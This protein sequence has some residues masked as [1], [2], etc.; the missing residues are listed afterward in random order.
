MPDKAPLVEC[1][2]NFSE[3]RRMDVQDAIAESI[4]SVQGVRLL[5]RTSD[6]DHNRTVMTFSGAP[7]PVAEA[8]FRAIRTAAQLIDLEQHEGVHPR[9]GA[10]DVLPFVPLRGATMEG[11]VLLAR[12]LGQR[13]GQELGLPVYLYEAAATRPE[14]RNIADIRRGQ[15]E[16]LKHEMHLPHRQPDYGPAQLGKAGAVIIGARKPLIAYNVYLTTDDVRIARRI[17][18]AIRHSGGGL[19]GVKALGLLV[20][21]QAQVSMNL[22]DYK[23]TPVQRVMEMI[24]REAEQY[25]VRIARS[26]LVGLIPQD[27]LL[28]AA[29]WYLQLHDYSPQMLLEQQLRQDEPPLVP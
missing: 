19:A 6:P 25:G 21:G 9:I 8:A 5:H 17:A 20:K 27:A 1:V 26:E 23:R 12:E 11:C 15:Y 3:G 4:A 2:P 14:R 18:N 29:A 13:V 22:V 24:R 10:T 28:Q 16:Q 7:Q